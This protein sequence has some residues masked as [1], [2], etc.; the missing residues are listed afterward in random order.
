MY[1]KKDDVRYSSCT[2]VS[3][4]EMRGFF[5]VLKFLRTCDGTFSSANKLKKKYRFIWFI[6]FD[7]LYLIHQTTTTGTGYPNRQ[8]YENH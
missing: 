1:G 7:P 5:F 8:D 4:L 6:I 3:P 2:K